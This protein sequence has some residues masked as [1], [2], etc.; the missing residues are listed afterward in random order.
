MFLFSLK[1]PLPYE[2]GY[3][4]RTFREGFERNFKGQTEQL[5]KH[6]KLRKAGVVAQEG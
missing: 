5:S 3:C 6:C 4:L 2:I 1:L